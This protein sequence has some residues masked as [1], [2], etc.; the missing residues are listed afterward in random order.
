MD[1]KN[2]VKLIVLNDYL[3]FDRK[4]YQLFGFSLGRPIRLKT[5]LYFLVISGI[6]LI[7]YF[8]PF[9][10][11][12]LIWLPPIYLVLI[13][14]GLAYLLSGVRTEGRSPIAFFRS[15]FLYHFRKKQDVTYFRGRE[16]KKPRNLI[17][18]GY[19]TV[20][21]EK[22]QIKKFSSKKIKFKNNKV[23]TTNVLDRELLKY[24]D[25]R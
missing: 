12:L 3:K 25:F 11:Y 23:I 5:L 6:E 2:R 20:T 7:I 14:A 4:I 16:V 1:K 22:D 9:T 19:A 15:L 18:V 17:F 10:K 21:Y 24:M 8:T 13:P